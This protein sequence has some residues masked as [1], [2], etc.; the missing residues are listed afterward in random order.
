VESIQDS[1]KKIIAKAST[2]TEVSKCE[3]HDVEMHVFKHPFEDRNIVTCPECGREQEA[4][5]NETKRLRERQTSIDRRLHNSMMAPRFIEKTLENYNATTDGQKKALSLANWFIENHGKVSGMI[6]I[7]KTGTGK[8]H[9]A[10]GIIHKII[11]QGGTALIT[12]AMKII[13]TIKDS[14]RDYETKEGD[15]IDLYT[16]PGLLVIDEIGVQF[17]SDTEK[18]YISEI[19]NDRYEAMRPTLLL[20]NIKLD[21]LIDQLGD[22]PID[23]FREGGKIV[24]FDWESHRKSKN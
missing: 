2:K 3:K 14:W 4:I 13:R 7:G 20:G 9:L 24:Q 1:T 16:Q 15:I 12:T 22:R 10:C 23:R 21:E 6:F 5:A 11:E 19:I 18:L 8:N 17:G